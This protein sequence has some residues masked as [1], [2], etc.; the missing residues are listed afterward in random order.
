MPVPE[1][2]SLPHYSLLHYFTL[3][4]LSYGRRES[5]VRQLLTFQSSIQPVRYPAQAP[6]VPISK[7]SSSNDD[8][9]PNDARKALQRW[10]SPKRRGAGGTEPSPP[11]VRDA[12]PHMDA[13]LAPQSEGRN[14][15]FRRRSAARNEQDWSRRIGR[16]SR[17]RLG[18][19]DY[20]GPHMGRR[21][22]RP[23][24]YGPNLGFLR[25]NELSGRS[26]SRLQASSHQ[27][28]PASIR[29]RPGGVPPIL[30]PSS[31]STTIRA[32]SEN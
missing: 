28:S 17:G 1:T 21:E 5:A 2:V 31:T 27:G 26:Q 29:Q 4:P 7:P 13:T 18:G 25:G 19:G 20:Q 3:L 32:V 12:L 24:P 15:S 23:R 8:A 30:P 14:P 16:W 22:E 6:E 11:F 9:L 10:R